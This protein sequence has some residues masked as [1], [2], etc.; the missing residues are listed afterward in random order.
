MKRNHFLMALAMF[1]SVFSL[2]AQ[3]KEKESDTTKK[4]TKE[5]PLEPE[6]TVSFTAKE[7]TWLSLDVHPNGETII[8]DMM[9][10]LY[11]IPIQGGKASKITEGMAYD[12]H[13]R[14]SP[15]GKSIV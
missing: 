11:T 14:Y 7:G 4:A 9:G 15:D 1:L 3:S 5:L 13:P 6:R 12:V 2:F 8:F 10:D